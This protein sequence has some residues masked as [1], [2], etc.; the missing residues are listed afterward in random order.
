MFLKCIPILEYPSLTPKLPL[1]LCDS[2][3]PVCLT[4]ANTFT[5]FFI[6]IKPPSPDRSAVIFNQQRHCDI[7]SKYCTH[8]QTRRWTIKSTASDRIFHPVFF[9]LLIFRSAYNKYTAT[10]RLALRRERQ[11]LSTVFPS[12]SITLNVL[13]GVASIQ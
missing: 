11:F 12:V 7:I 6:H 2:A 5:A 3:V 13:S 10:Q 9:L 8:T 4:D 1:Q